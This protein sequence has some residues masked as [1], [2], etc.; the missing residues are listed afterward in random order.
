MPKA[1]CK[2]F[3]YES[4]RKKKII[5]I[6]KGSYKIDSLFEPNLPKMINAKKNNKFEERERDRISKASSSFQSMLSFSSS[7]SS[8]FYSGARVPSPFQY[9]KALRLNINNNKKKKKKRF[10]WRKKK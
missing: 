7:S 9:F 8:S 2:F 6:E 4:Y 3:L 10:M 5:H 1:I